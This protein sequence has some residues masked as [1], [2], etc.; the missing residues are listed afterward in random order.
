MR[1]DLLQPLDSTP[2]PQQQQQQL[3]N[4]MDR[5]N[6]WAVHEITYTSG[7]YHCR[8]LMAGE[9]SSSSSPLSTLGF[10]PLMWSS[11]LY[12]LSVARECGGRS[13]VWS[14]IL[15]GRRRFRW[16][17]RWA[18][19]CI[20]AMTWWVGRWNWLTGTCHKT[21]FI[22]HRKFTM[23]SCRWRR[24]Q[25]W[26]IW[27]ELSWAGWLLPMQERPSSDNRADY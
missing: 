3:L 12:R 6:L 14:W 24:R 9:R 11:T 27:A 21:W 7:R 10:V 17:D 5:R 20:E 18:I 23:L 8:N 1:R 4:G 15:L 25:R 22:V 2:P 19:R 13:A 16:M 26:R